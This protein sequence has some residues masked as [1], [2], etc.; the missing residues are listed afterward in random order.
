MCANPAVHNRIQDPNSFRNSLRTKC[1]SA[2]AL[3]AF[4]LTTTVALHGLLLFSQPGE[5]LRFSPTIVIRQFSVSDE[6]NKAAVLYCVQPTS[7]RNS[8]YGVAGIYDLSTTPHLLQ[9]LKLP[10]L[11][12]NMT[13]AARGHRGAISTE[14]GD[15]YAL[16][17]CEISLPPRLLGKHHA[18]YVPVLECATDGSLILIGDV[19]SISAWDPACDKCLWRRDDLKVQ[20]GCFLADTTRF[21]CG[22]HSGEILELDALTGATNRTISSHCL[23]AVSLEVSR[24]GE[25]IVA[26]DFYYGSVVV[27]LKND[28]KLWS[29]PFSVSGSVPRFSPDSRTLLASCPCKRSR[30]VIYSAATGDEVGE[31]VGP[32]GE[33]HGLTVTRN[34]TVFGWDRTGTITAWNLASRSIL[35]QL[36][37][38]C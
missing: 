22:L 20:C 6:C 10:K 28:K 19:D 37:P 8:I 9:R 33:L 13:S 5:K 29:R 32:K 27:D 24:D 36:H 35:Y 2:F 17:L 26:T 7:S 1:L 34:G 16:N 21:F 25:R 3:S 30:V 15:L 31:L 38:P 11:P 12:W 23:R 18:G 14:C 4:A